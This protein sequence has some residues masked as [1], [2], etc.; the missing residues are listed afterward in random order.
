[1][2]LN[3]GLCWCGENGNLCSGGFWYCGYFGNDGWL[4]GVLIIFFDDVYGEKGYDVL[5]YVVC[6]DKN[7]LLRIFFYVLKN[8][9]IY[10]YYGDDDGGDDCV[11]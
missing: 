1:M 11:K 3:G 10:G 8:V 4:N 6:C 2:K 9:L 5:I 7:V